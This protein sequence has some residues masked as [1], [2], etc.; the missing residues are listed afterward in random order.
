MFCWVGASISRITGICPG[1]AAAGNEV[2][3]N[4]CGRSDA[5]NFPAP[6]SACRVSAVRCVP[7]SVRQ[8]S[9]SSDHRSAR[10][11]LVCSR[12][13]PA[14]AGSGGGGQEG[15][16]CDMCSAGGALCPPVMPCTACSPVSCRTLPGPPLH[17]GR[18]SSLC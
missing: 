2:Q 10:V 16:G 6:G 14:S 13:K 15:Q 17:P 18:G 4:Q 3:N 11:P 12:P 1:E 8:L 7:G 5:E 9:F